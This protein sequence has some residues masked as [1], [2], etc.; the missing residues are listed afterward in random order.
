MAFT[1]RLGLDITLDAWGDDPF[2]S[3]FNEELGAVVQ[4]HAKT[5]PRLTWSNAMH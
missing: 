2:R 5:A 1:S 3:L 4:S